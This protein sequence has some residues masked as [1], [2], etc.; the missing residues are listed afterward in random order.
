MPAEKRK[1]LAYF[2][3]KIQHMIAFFIDHHSDRPLPQ[4]RPLRLCD[5]DAFFG[6]T[7]LKKEHINTKDGWLFLPEAKMGS[8]YVP[9]CVIARSNIEGCGFYSD[10][11]RRA[12]LTAPKKPACERSYRMGRNGRMASAGTISGIRHRPIF[13]KMT[14]PKKRPIP[15]WGI[16]G[17][18]WEAFT[19]ICV[20][21]SE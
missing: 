15:S 8:R 20:R 17:S 7:E 14:F 9:L 4:I 5:W 11:R 13:R 10:L 21:S 12:W 3:Q 2:Q 6:A 18:P 16:D 19:E 1:S